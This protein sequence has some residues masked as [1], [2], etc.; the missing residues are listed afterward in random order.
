[1][2]LEAIPKT[3][4][5]LFQAGGQDSKMTIAASGGVRSLHGRFVMFFIPVI[6]KLTLRYYRYSLATRG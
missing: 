2:F 1:M 6:L 4:L 3:F 5:Q